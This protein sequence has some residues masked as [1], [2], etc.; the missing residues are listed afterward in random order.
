MNDQVF[1][2]V[3]RNRGAVRVESRTFKG[4]QSVHVR[5][6]Y[7]DPN[8]GTL[9]PSPKGVALKSH[10]IREIAAALLSAAAVCEAE[11]AE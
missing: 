3:L 8:D 1:A 9:Q 4:E 11:A 6:Y 2:T 5:F 7:Q 10:E